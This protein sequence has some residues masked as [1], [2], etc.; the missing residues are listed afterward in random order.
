MVLRDGLSYMLDP[1]YLG[2]GLA[3]DFRASLDEALSNTPADYVTAINE[4]RK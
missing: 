2:L 1:R 4:D 3:A